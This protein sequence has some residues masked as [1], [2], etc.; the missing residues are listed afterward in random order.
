MNKN[1]L[2]NLKNATENWG[3]EC[4]RYEIKDIKLSDTIRKVMNLEAETERKKRAEILL[5]EGRKNSEINM[6]IA[7]KTSKILEAEWKS[8]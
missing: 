4:T 6:A 2:D 5:S 8:E 7:H 1:I 3:I